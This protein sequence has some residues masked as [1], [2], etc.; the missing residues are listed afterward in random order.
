MAKPDKRERKR[1]SNQLAHINRQAEIFAGQFKT[2]PMKKVWSCLAHL[3]LLND[4]ME[5][6]LPSRVILL[7]PFD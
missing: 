6:G 7:E 1:I 5:V 3:C 4:G 2:L